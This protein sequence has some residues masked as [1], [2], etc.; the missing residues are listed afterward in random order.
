LNRPARIL[1]IIT[2]VYWSA[3]FAATHIP[4]KFVPPVPVNDKLEHFCGYG[5]LASLLFSA[6][7]FRGR[8]KPA[9]IVVFVLGLMMCYGAVDEWTQILVN[10]DCELADWFADCSGAAVAVVGGTLIAPR[11]VKQPTAD[12]H[13]FPIDVH[14]SQISDRDSGTSL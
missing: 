12:G 1:T 14:N 13:G 9:E 4:A 11:L 6:L 10:R 2:I 8:R 5:G 7:Y 3:L